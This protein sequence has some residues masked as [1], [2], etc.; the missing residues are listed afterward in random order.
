MNI[1]KRNIIQFIVFAA[2]TFILSSCLKDN[3]GIDWTDAVKGK[4]YAEF[5]KAGY[6]PYG[7]VPQAAP[8]IWTTSITIASDQPPTKDVTVNFGIDTDAINN[9]NKAQFALDSNFIFYKP[10]PYL[11]TGPS[12]TIKAGTQTTWISVEIDSL[13]SVDVTQKYMIAISLTS[14]SATDVP[15]TSNRNSV[16]LCMV[17]KN[18]YDGIYTVT[19]T[20]VDH[21][22]ALLTG[23]YPCTFQLRTSGAN[24]CYVYDMT[25]GIVD[26]YHSIRN[27]GSLSLYGLFGLVVDFNPDGSGNI[28]DVVNYYGQPASNTR[29]AELDPSG[30]NAWDPSTKNIAIKYFMIQTNQSTGAGPRTEFNETWTYVGPRP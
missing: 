23:N 12:V 25:P 16:L 30:T 21:V 5:T 3:V 18:K 4:M 24:Q 26:I 13:A 2:F 20:M 28:V 29:S 7:I 11:K 19:G 15:L 10:Y 1:M 8:L 6:W 14:T 17:I 22:N 27:N 9:Y